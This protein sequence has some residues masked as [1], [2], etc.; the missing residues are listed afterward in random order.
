M[1]QF[2]CELQIAPLKIHFYPFIDTTIHF[3]TEM[4]LP[5]TRF[6]Y[7]MVEAIPIIHISSQGGDKRNTFS[8]KAATLTY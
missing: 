5:V 2:H 3:G 4:I 7:G 6:T 8:H 1:I